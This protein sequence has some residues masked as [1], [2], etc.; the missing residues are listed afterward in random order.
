MG[1]DGAR[2]QERL[3]WRGPVAIYLI[4][5][6]LEEQEAGVRWS[7]PCTDVN[8]EADERPPLEDITSQRSEDRDWE[9][10]LCVIVICEVYARVVW[11]SNKSSYQSKLVYGHSKKK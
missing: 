7:P 6:R 4:G 2:N 10:S 5:L 8:P 9:T 11:V 3:C 1:P